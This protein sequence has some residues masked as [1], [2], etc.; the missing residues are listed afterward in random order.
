M[1]WST[2]FMTVLAAI[3]VK[4]NAGKILSIKLGLVSIATIVRLTEKN[5]V[6]Y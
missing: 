6:L 5:I 2:N 1:K 4:N 3:S